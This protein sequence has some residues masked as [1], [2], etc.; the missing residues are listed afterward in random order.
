MYTQIGTTTRTTY[1][2]RAQGTKKKALTFY[3]NL[4][5]YYLDPAS[6]LFVINL[7]R[8]SE[9]NCFF[10]VAGCTFFFFCSHLIHK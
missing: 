8:R 1:A 3:D 5:S 4:L 10:V 6:L 2:R 9:K 7:L